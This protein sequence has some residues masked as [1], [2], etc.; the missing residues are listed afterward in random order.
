M[1][2][3]IAILI[4]IVFLGL[5]R[6][7][8]WFAVNNLKGQSGIEIIEGVFRL[9]YRENTGAAF[10]ILSGTRWFFV[11]FTSVVLIA[12]IVLF[13]KF[14][15]DRPHFWLR[16][17]MSVIFAGAVGNFIDRVISGYVVDMF[18]FYWFEFP[19]FNVADMCVV[20]GAIALFII[21]FFFIEDKSAKKAKKGIKEETKQEKEEKEEE[22]IEEETGLGNE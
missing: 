3:F 17:S 1:I 2:Y 22:K 18:Y 7:T 15:K 11:I 6:L 5:D 10:S 13:I 14:P 12:M 8:K 20:C 16:I 4:Q 19:V 9:S 21:Y